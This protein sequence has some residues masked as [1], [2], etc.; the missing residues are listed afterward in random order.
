MQA[1]K[2]HKITFLSVCW[3]DLYFPRIISIQYVKCIC[4]STLLSSSTKAKNE[5]LM[6]SLEFC[7]G[8]KQQLTSYPYPSHPPT[9]PCV[10]C[11]QIDQDVSLSAA[12]PMLMLC[13]SLKV[14][15]TEA[16]GDWSTLRDSLILPSVGSRPKYFTWKNKRL[17]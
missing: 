10:C 2:T 3:Y 12:V 4:A 14:F 6:M 1:N 15:T 7:E 11:C 5:I 8:K 13:L 16:A 17:L 9:Q